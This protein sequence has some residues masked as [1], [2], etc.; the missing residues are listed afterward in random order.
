MKMKELITK[1]HS[2]GF[3]DIS[4]R[5]I[6]HYIDKGMLPAPEKSHANQ[7]IYSEEHYRILKIIGLLKKQNKTW[8]EIEYVLDDKLNLLNNVNISLREASSRECYMEELQCIEEWSKI[9]KEMR[10]F[11]KEELLSYVECDEK[12]FDFLTDNSLISNKRYYDFSDMHLVRCI[13][14]MKYFLDDY[15]KNELTATKKFFE[16]INHANTLCDEL[17]KFTVEYIYSFMFSNLIKSMMFVKAKN[18]S[19]AS[20]EITKS[21]WTWDTISIGNFEFAQD[22]YFMKISPE[23]DDDFWVK[24]LWALDEK[25]LTANELFEPIEE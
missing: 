21:T 13:C 22:C 24:Y 11:T 23:P 16:F 7:A 20:T 5:M 1:L 12:L 25:G 17:V 10:F 3:D 9:D 19:Y 18:M 4:E 2:D 15:Y 8:H 14:Y 6:R